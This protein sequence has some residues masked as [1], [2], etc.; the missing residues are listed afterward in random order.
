MVHIYNS[1]Y[2]EDGARKDCVPSLAQAIRSYLKKMTKAKR[3]GGVVK[4]VECLPSKYE[5]LSSNLDTE[6]K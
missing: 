3:T 1:S 6:K 4:L 5:V 2:A